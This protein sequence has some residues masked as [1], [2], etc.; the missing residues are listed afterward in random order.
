M[1]LKAGRRRWWD[2]PALL[3]IFTK[4]DGVQD[5]PALSSF[6]WGGHTESDVLLRPWDSPLLE[7]R[8]ATPLAEVGV[9]SVS[10]LLAKSATRLY[11]RDLHHRVPVLIRVVDGVAEF[12]GKG[13]TGW[14]ARR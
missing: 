13:R 10:S 14:W 6:P 3:C 11:Y 7:G 1:G 8:V 2:M 5:G 12:S 4:Q 9:C